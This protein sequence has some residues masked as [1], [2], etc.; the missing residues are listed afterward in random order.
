MGDD[1][2]R[3]GP[4]PT[5]YCRVNHSHPCSRG[6]FRRSTTQT[7]FQLQLEGGR[8]RESQPKKQISRFPLPL[9]TTHLASQRSRPCTSPLLTFHS[10]QHYRQHNHHHHDRHNQQETARLI[11]SLLLIATRLRQLD[12]RAPGIIP[13]ILHI[14]IDCI[15]H[16][17]L[18]AHDRRDIT[19]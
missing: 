18:L 12:I 5:E 9:L 8:E 16:I 11:P 1:I 15:D 2:F 10:P 13:H 3:A 6:T 4:P 17:A 14:D 7:P 19:E